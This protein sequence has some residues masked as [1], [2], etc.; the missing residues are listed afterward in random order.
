MRLAGIALVLTVT[1]ELT[2]RYFFGL[3]NP[4]LYKSDPDCGYLAA[5]NQT[6]HRFGA[7]NHI[8]AHGMRSADVTLAKPEGSVRILILG[9]SVA[10]GDTF[11]DQQTIFPL[12]IAKHLPTILSRRVEVLNASTK[13]WAPSNEVGYLR[14]RGTFQS[15]W[16]VIVLNAGDL[17]Q[18][19]ATFAAAQDIPVQKPLCALAE[20]ATRYVLPRLLGQLRS[21]AGSLP[22]I[23]ADATTQTPPVLSSL[24]EAIHVTESKGARLLIVYSPGRGG[25][26]EQAEYRSKTIGMLREWAEQNAIAMLDLTPALLASN[27]AGHYRDGL[28]LSAAGHREAAH[29]IEVFLQ[30]LPPNSRPRSQAPCLSPRSSHNTGVISPRA[31]TFTK[32]GRNEE[33]IDD[34]NHRRIGWFDL[35]KSF[36]SADAR[37]AAAPQICFAVGQLEAAEGKWDESIQHFRRCHALDG[38]FLPHIMELYLH[39]V[40]RP[41]LAVA[42]VQ[43][44]PRRLFDVYYQLRDEVAARSDPAASR[45]MGSVR[46]TLQAVAD[47]PTAPGLVLVSLAGLLKEQ[48]EYGQADWHLALAVALAQSGRKDEAVHE[49]EIC[50]HLRPQ[51]LA[52]RQLIEAANTHVTT[53]AE[54]VFIAVRK[55]EQGQQCTS[56]G[57]LVAQREERLLAR[58]D[59]TQLTIL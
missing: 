32:R 53:T 56:V 19:F 58:P 29:A 12:L 54:Q 36:G 27:A 24:T 10:F 26:W 43:D 33:A 21:D 5:P 50:L 1:V 40:G 46:Q 34:T 3:G 55:Q 39:Q 28:H 14:S 17:V 35:R 15:D 49:A 51:Y 44:D 23:Q 37:T 38:T 47:R 25:Q 45:A 41:D 22:D 11:L 9:D 59:P 2:L 4:L 6:V 18:P 31:G 16:V 7:L 8:N 57:K 13:G 52:A 20:L 42:V 30:D 48:K